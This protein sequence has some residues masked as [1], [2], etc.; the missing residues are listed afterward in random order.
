MV[1]G[2]AELGDFLGGWIASF[3]P[4]SVPSTTTTSADVLL[5]V[6]G[7]GPSW[8]VPRICL[9]SPAAAWDPGR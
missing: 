1:E 2:R 4:K 8:P 5:N 9:T 3:P 6:A 7:S